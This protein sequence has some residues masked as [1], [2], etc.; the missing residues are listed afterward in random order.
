MKNAKP[1]CLLMNNLIDKQCF[2]V[3]SSIF[4]TNNCLNEVYPSFNRLYKELSSEFCLVDNFP[5]CFYFKTANCNDTKAMKS[6][7]WSLNNIIEESS[8]NLNIVLVIT[9][10]S[11]KNNVIMS[12]FHILYSQSILKKTI[13][14]VVNV[15][16]M[17]A[18][19]F[20][21]YI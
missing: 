15:T 18:E 1:Y 16:S 17:E 3:K 6:H 12:I 5:N 9:D 10:A 13:H 20:F 19:T 2:K 14:H 4:D 11:V 8:L 7:L 21:D